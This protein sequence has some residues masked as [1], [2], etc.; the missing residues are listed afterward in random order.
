MESL[1]DYLLVAQDKP[2]AEHYHRQADGQWLYSAIDGL[3]SR[4]TINS[5][6]C[7]LLSAAIDDRVE[8]PKPQPTAHP[9]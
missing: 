9:T 7:A 8:F 6:D 2:R 3:N 5:I 4:P 1:S